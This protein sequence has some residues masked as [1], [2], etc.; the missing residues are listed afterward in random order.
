MTQSART[1]IRI[2]VVEDEID[3]QELL[4]LHL[5]REGYHIDSVKNKKTTLETLQNKNTEF[6]LF[7]LN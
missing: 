6:A 2:L 7:L 1:P 3:I 5:G 4:V